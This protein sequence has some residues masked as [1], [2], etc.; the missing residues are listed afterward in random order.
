MLKKGLFLAAA[1]VLLSPPAQATAQ[2]GVLAEVG[3][4]VTADEAGGYM[5]LP[6]TLF[7]F[8]ETGCI[9]SVRTDDDGV[10]SFKLLPGEYW[11]QVFS[12]ASEI[13]VERFTVTDG[14]QSYLLQAHAQVIDGFEPEVVEGR[15]AKLLSHVVPAEKL[16]SVARR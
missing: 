12:G 14:R 11:V 4:R 5:G 10:F 2:S 6:A 3:G 8:N 9:G 13:A 16:T 7:V 1:L 15:P